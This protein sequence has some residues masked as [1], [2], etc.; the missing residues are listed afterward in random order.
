VTGTAWPLSGSA[1]QK[2]S[3]KFWGPK[4]TVAM[5]GASGVRVFRVIPVP[6]A[7][8]VRINIDIKGG[9]SWSEDLI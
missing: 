9:A 2:T 7:G 5:S 3:K 8:K 1:G 6:V 4:G